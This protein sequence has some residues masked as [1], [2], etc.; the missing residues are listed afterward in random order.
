MTSSEE[1]AEHIDR[2]VKV[3]APVAIR[4]DEQT[5]IKEF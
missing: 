3:A 5:G 2:A 4:G 1:R